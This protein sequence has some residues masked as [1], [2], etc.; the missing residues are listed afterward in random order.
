LILSG[1]TG[2][3]HIRAAEALER[4]CRE[5]YPDVEIFNM[6]LMDYVTWPF[7]RLY[8]GAYID[9]I[10][11]RPRVFDLMYDR[12]D[13]P[14]EE[15]YLRSMRLALQGLFLNPAKK[16][17]IE[18]KPDHIICT[19]F[20]PAEM[21]DRARRRGMTGIAP[22]SVVVTDYDVHW[23]WVLKTLDEFFVATEEAAQR[24]RARGI[25]SERIH[26]TG[27]PVCPAFSAP[28]TL[29]DSRAALG[30]DPN[31]ATIMIMSGGFGVGRIDQVADR[32]LAEMPEVQIVALAGRN[33]QLFT[34]LEKLAESHPGRLV[35]VAFTTEVERYMATADIVISKPGGL[36]TSE[37]LAMGKPL[38][39]I[40]PIPGQEEL[41]AVCVIEHGAGMFAVDTVG[42]LH[43]LH[44]IFGQPGRLSS[45]QDAARALG[46]PRAGFDILDCIAPKYLDLPVPVNAPAA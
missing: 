20:L 31:R 39:T 38:L 16:K 22:V 37:C 35:P 42:I 21:L 34:D 15:Q 29:H 44:A 18:F 23:I 32:V 26:I 5:R 2:G 14:P 1:S 7:R 46:K 8:A 6:D 24:I 41:N 40:D 11:N 33:K 43:K 3:G 4:C 25:D 19:H 36:T 9:I 10:K 30:L 12:T 45:M 17:L 28:Y 13:K 27:I